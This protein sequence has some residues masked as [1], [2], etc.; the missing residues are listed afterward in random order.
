M[1]KDEIEKKLLKKRIKKI[2]W[3]NMANLQNLQL[4]SWN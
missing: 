2:T 3:V 1:L 4:G